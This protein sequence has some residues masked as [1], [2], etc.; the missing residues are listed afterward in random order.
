MNCPFCSGKVRVHEASEAVTHTVPTCAKF[1]GED[2][3]T[4]LRNV[5]LQLVGPLEDDADWPLRPRDQ[6]AE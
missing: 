5:R 1:D 3:L 4:F 2:A 6:E